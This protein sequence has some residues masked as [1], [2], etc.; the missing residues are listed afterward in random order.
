MESR[1]RSKIN[2]DKN[3]D[4]IST[5]CPEEM[6]AEEIC[7]V[8]KKTGTDFEDVRRQLVDRLWR[9][10]MEAIVKSEEPTQGKEKII[11]LKEDCI[12]EK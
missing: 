7:W 5:L 1:K 12:S 8:L 2:N 4:D 9:V 6:S 10:I 3:Y 11:V